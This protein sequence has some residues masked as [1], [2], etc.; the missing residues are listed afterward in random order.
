MKIV[1][2]RAAKRSTQIGFQTD[3]QHQT[4]IVCSTM[5]RPQIFRSG[6]KNSLMKIQSIDDVKLHSYCSATIH[7]SPRDYKRFLVRPAGSE[8]NFRLHKLLPYFSLGKQ[9]N[10]M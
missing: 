9:A 7:N 3:E 1:G 6:N 2:G 8:F 10:F 5:G 4:P